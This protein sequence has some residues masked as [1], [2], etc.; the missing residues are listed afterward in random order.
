MTDP[1]LS[2]L[3]VTAYD[4]HQHVDFGGY[5][6]GAPDATMWLRSDFEE[7]AAMM[8]EAEIACSVLMPSYD[9]DKRSG[10]QSTA[11]V[12][13]GL[14]EYQSWGPDL[15]PWLGCTVEP[16]H[17]SGAVELLENTLAGGRFQIASWHNRYQGLSV[18]AP[19]M[20]EFA[21]VAA[22][23]DCVLFVHGTGN[24]DHEEAW[25]IAHLVRAF[26]HVRFVVLD[27]M[28]TYASMHILADLLG[29]VDNTWLDTAGATS[30]VH[31][32]RHIGNT[33][34]WHRILFGSDYYGK[35]RGGSPALMR[36]QLQLCD[37]S[38]DT[39]LDVFQRN[40]RDLLGAPPK[41]GDTNLQ[42]HQRRLHDGGNT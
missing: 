6:A 29:D 8:K 18:D 21:E 26:P 27:A 32:V 13:E 25:R 4:A 33:I 9:Y 36:H 20:F 10:L 35:T 34:G 11:K 24:L 16:Q 3:R 5:S 23:Y 42:H 30:F 1:G 40:L 14:L 15:F 39:L 7:R 31:L 2:A 22:R 38:G 12:I 28:M 19:V 41:R 17:Y 37:L